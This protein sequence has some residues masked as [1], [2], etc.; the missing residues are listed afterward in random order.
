MTT[1]YTPLSNLPY[2]QAS[3]PADLPANLQS[4]AQSL[5]G[6]TVLRFATTAE[7]D[8]KLPTP[9]AGQVAWIASPGRLMNYTGSVWVPVGAVPVFRVNSDG[10]TTTSTAYVETLTS[11]TGDPMNAV[12]T[13]PA[14]GSVIISVGCYMFSSA[15]NVGTYMSA[16]IRNSAGTVVLSANDARAALVN[17]PNRASVSTQFLVTGLAVGTTHTA[18]PAY[19]SG[20]TT[21][22]S[23]FD[24]RY[25][26]V[27]PIM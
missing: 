18:T 16:N 24:T 12:F 7:R 5:D 23:N 8:A 3:D 22:T 15:T 10:G 25:I 9:V 27:D 4:L 20:A 14:S 17:S 19:R 21:N 1:Q 11:A 13:V 2:P 6:R 26:R